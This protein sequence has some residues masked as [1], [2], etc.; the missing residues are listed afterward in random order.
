MNQYCKVGRGSQSVHQIAASKLK[1][2]VHREYVII[3]RKAVYYD[4]FDISSV[5]IVHYVKSVFTKLLHDQL[6]LACQQFLKLGH[7]DIKLS[8]FRET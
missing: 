6:R 3:A 7:F 4:L 5:S 1:Y 8:V 2:L